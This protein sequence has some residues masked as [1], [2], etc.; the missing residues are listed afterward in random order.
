MKSMP[1]ESI[2]CCVTS[3]PYDDMRDYKGYS[4][5]I[6]GAGKEIY[7]LLKPG[8]TMAMVI[9]DQTVNKSLTGTSFKIT[10]ELQEQAGFNIHQVCIYYKNGMPGASEIRMRNDHEYIII[11][12]KGKDIITFNKDPLKV[13]CKYKEVNRLVK[14]RQKDGRLTTSMLSYQSDTKCR[15]T[16]WKINKL[17]TN[18]MRIKYGHPATMPE[19]LAVDIIILLSNKGDVILDPFNGSGTTCV[20]ASNLNRDYIGI[21]ISKDYCELAERRMEVEGNRFQPELDVSNTVEVNSSQTELDVS[22]GRET[23]VT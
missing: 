15:G 19:E 20:M 4:C 21:D 7:R 3:P 11:F 5:D 9:A 1:S 18:A 16:V 22:N 23:N 13:P 2:D 14:R 6:V 17:G 12:K 8:G 10:T